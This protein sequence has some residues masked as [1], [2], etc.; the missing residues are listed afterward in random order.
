MDVGSIAYVEREKMEPTKL[1]EIKCGGVPVLAHPKSLKFNY[2]DTNNFICMLKESGL[3]GVEVYNPHNS[4]EKREELLEIC[5]KYDL[6]PTVGSDFH[7]F[8]DGIEIG[9][10]INENL[11]ISDY[12][13]IT[14]LK[15]KKHI[16]DINNKKKNGWFLNQPFFE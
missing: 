15:E 16:I 7:S 8:K 10:G 14:K 11:K 2:T 12:S 4:E 6:I 13:I 1:I 3:C 5:D 9:L